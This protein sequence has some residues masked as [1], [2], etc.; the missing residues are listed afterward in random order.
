MLVI[1]KRRRN[2]HKVWKCSSLYFW[3]L[4]TGSVTSGSTELSFS[5][6]LCPNFIM[7]RLVMG[8]EQ[9]WHITMSANANHHIQI[10]INI[11]IVHIFPFIYKVFIKL[12]IFFLSSTLSNFIGENWGYWCLCSKGFVNC[13]DWL[14]SKLF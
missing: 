2:S 12:L 3:L 10:Y 13:H 14:S 8:K 11:S 1:K 4:H 6:S 5:S 9:Y 7:M